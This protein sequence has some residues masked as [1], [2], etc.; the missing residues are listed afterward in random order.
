MLPGQKN[1]GCVYKTRRKMGAAECLGIG[2]NH[3]LQ[4][5]DMGIIPGE[6]QMKLNRRIKPECQ[7]L[8]VA[9]SQWKQK[10]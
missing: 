1:M 6:A 8:N 3:L 4:Q 10:L 7:T 9:W 5:R 2:F